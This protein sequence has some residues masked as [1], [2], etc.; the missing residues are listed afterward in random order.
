MKHLSKFWK[1]ENRISHTLVENYS[2][3]QRRTIF[4]I[5]NISRFE[6][7][8]RISGA[9][10]ENLRALELSIFFLLQD[11]WN[12]LRRF[13]HYGWLAVLCCLGASDCCRYAFIERIK[14]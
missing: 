9:K 1:T 3:P 13:L 12:L 14:N 7:G 4:S 2:N 10:I 5:Q 6:T 11:S 8:Y